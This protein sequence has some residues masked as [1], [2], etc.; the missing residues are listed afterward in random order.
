MRAAWLALLLLTAGG[1]FPAA[2]FSADVSETAAVSG[3]AEVSGTGDIVLATQ[4]REGVLRV[5]D[6]QA[7]V[8]TSTSVV[9]E[10]AVDVVP[11]VNVVMRK[12]I[13]DYKGMRG[14]DTAWVDVKVG[15]EEAYNGWV[16]NWYPDSAGMQNPRYTV[17]LAKCGPADA[18]RRLTPAEAG[19]VVVRGGG[20]VGGD[21]EAPSATPAQPAADVSASAPAEAAPA[22]PA[23]FMPQTSDGEPA[24]APAEEAPAGDAAPAQEQGQGGAQQGAAE[25]PFFVPG[26]DAGDK[27]QLHKM[28][29][30]QGQ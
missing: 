19:G 18:V 23:Q 12:C 5:L 6:K 10:H 13:K 3:T 11:D 1:V 25:D 22:A 15:G 2:G 14:L 20:D 16:F 27:E 9:L 29:D 7:N 17:T 28:M 4:A 26:V 8:V 30:G 21:E 24:A